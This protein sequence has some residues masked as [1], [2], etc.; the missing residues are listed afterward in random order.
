MKFNRKYTGHMPDRIGGGELRPSLGRGMDVPGLEDYEPGC[1]REKSC[2]PIRCG[3]GRQ[4]AWLTV[5]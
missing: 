2:W 5:D 4:H 1:A 3:A